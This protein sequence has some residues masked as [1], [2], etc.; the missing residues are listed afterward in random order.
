MYH[1][2]LNFVLLFVAKS[3]AVVRTAVPLTLSTNRDQPVV[4][5]SKPQ[6]LF[7]DSR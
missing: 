7:K 6:I 5:E 1:A 4:T 2:N 3:S